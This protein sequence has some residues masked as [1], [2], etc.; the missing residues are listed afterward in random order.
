MNEI[1][2][3]ATSV[4]PALDGLSP[5]PVDAADA[6]GGS[7]TSAEFGG[8]VMGSGRRAAI[9]TVIGFGTMQ[10]LRL[11]FNLALAQ[12]VAPR[13][14]GVMALVNVF[15]QLLHMFSDLGIRQ[16]VIAHPRGDEPAFLRTA[17]TMQALRGLFLWLLSVAIAWPVA[18]FY[19]NDNQLWK[20]LRIRQAQHVRR[21][22]ANQTASNMT[23][24]KFS[25]EDQ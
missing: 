4:E 8:S 21:A 2:K 19:E 18:A 23:I 15:L 12:L 22:V 7:L 1:E 24:A 6:E 10:V 14:F 13:I 3:L 16:C 9:W 5:P 17:W 11:A 25:V 20:E